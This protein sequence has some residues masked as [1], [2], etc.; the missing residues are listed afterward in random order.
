MDID[1]FDMTVL[2]VLDKAG[3][4]Q[5]TGL[6]IKALCALIKKRKATAIYNHVRALAE[7]GLVRNSMSNGRERYYC[8]T[9]DGQ[10]EVRRA[11]E[12][13]AQMRKGKGKS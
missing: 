12:A 1:M 2:S 10:A 11:E 7:K 5:W 3:A 4:N 9:E 6:S 13:I 8:L